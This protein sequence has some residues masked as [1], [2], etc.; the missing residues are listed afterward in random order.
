METFDF[1]FSATRNKFFKA[2][3]SG[4]VSKSMIVS[5][6]FHDPH[7]VWAGFLLTLASIGTFYCNG[8]KVPYFVWFGTDKCSDEVRNRA[9]DPPW[10][11]LAAMGIRQVPFIGVGTGSAWPLVYAAG[12]VT[13]G[14]GEAVVLYGIGW[15]LAKLLR[16]LGLA[17]LLDSGRGTG[18]H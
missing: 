17:G 9:G 7:L 5:A 12:V 3:F 16:R 10:N 1:T 8:L 2:S 6:G 11:M 18:P 13:I 15:P 14:V 4:F